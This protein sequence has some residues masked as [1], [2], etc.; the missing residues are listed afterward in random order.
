ML[1][2]LVG[3]LLV[4]VLLPIALRIVAEA[5]PLVLL[6]SA[7]GI[8]VA[9]IAWLTWSYPEWFF[10]AGLLSAATFVG[11]ALWLVGLKAA[12]FARPY[13]S[14]ASAWFDSIEWSERNVAI[15]LLLLAVASTA[16]VLIAA[17][18]L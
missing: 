14:R 13:A 18:Y 8:G 15:V 2:T 10:A 9:L 12:R 5:L 7:I 11:Y 3:V 4:I 16:A 1:W 6:L 17:P